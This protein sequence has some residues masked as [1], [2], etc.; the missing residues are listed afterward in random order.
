MIPLLRAKKY[1]RDKENRAPMKEHEQ[2]EK[3]EASENGA[4]ENVCELTEKRGSH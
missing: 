1:G 2:T 3:K 4:P